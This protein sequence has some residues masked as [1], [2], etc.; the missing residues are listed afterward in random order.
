MDFEHGTIS[1]MV[2]MSFD[3]IFTVFGMVD[4]VTVGVCNELKT[5]IDLVPTP[6][7]GHEKE[8][9][10]TSAVDRINGST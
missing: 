4:S 9:D 10:A 7:A 5:S 1:A 2:V 3:G 8:E 6:R